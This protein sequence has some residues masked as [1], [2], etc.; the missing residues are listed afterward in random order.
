MPNYQ[1]ILRAV[2]QGLETLEVNS[3]YLDVIENHY[4]VRGE[5]KK[6]KTAAAVKSNLKKSFLSHVRKRTKKKSPLRPFHF[7]GLRFTP[8]DIELLERKGQ[9]LQTDA[10]GNPPDP[11]ALSQVLRT[12]GAYLDVHDCRLLAISWCDGLGALYPKVILR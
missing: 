1:N 11:H 2:G 9:A 5:S 7:A 8:R 4:I 3:F 6:R 10:E 12:V